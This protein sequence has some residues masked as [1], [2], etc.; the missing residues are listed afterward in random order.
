MARSRRRRPTDSADPGE[1]DIETIEGTPQEEALFSAMR[2]QRFT[3]QTSEFAR[4]LS[5]TSEDRVR[6]LATALRSYISKH[7]PKA[8]EKRRSLQDYRTN[9]YVLM[10]SASTM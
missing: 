10:A 9:P 5:L 3:F 2:R 1:P 6:S 4:L 8:I 7:L